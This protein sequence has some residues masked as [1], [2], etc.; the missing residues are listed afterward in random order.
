MKYAVT[1]RHGGKYAPTSIVRNPCTS[2]F[3]RNFEVKA[4]TV[5]TWPMGC[6]IWLLSI[7]ALLINYKKVRSR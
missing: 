4:A 6:G 5:T 2:F 1:L 7:F 3:E